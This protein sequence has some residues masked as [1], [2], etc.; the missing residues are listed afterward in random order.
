PA[1]DFT[2]FGEVGLSF[3]WEIIK[4]IKV[5]ARVKYLSGI[6][7]ISTEESN[8]TFRTDTTIY[9]LSFTSDYRI[10]TSGPAAIDPTDIQNFDPGN[11]APSSLSFGGNSG[12]A[13]DLGLEVRPMENLRIG[14]SIQDVGSINWDQNARN[15][16][17]QGTFAYGAVDPLKGQDSLGEGGIV[18]RLLNVVPEGLLDSVIG[19]LG[20]AEEQ[21]NF[22]APL[23]RKFNVSAFWEPI[24]VIGVGAMYQNMTIGDRSY[25]LTSLFASVKVGRALTLGLSYTGGMKANMVGF[26]T[27]MNAGP[28]QV[29][30]SADNILG[31]VSPLNANSGHI[32][33]GTALTFG[34]PKGKSGA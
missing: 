16:H 29:Y 9:G 26:H 13:F 12:F 2:T 4:Q 21:K 31:V 15:F 32:R 5:G 34:N 20:F 7:H 11:V 28:L 24:P 33:I 1:M 27:R 14:A 3:S 22:S 25:Q 30:I 17:S 6:Q 10:R 8:L 18:Q 23:R 19:S